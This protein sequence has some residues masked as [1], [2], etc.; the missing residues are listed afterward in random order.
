MRMDYNS[1]SRLSMYNRS[2]LDTGNLES[3]S[4]AVSIRIRVTRSLI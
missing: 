3:Q 4:I 2:A 1:M